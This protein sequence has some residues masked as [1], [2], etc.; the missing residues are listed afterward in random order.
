VLR[1]ASGVRPAALVGGVVESRPVMHNRW[2]GTP[3]G[4]SLFTYRLHCGIFG[5]SGFSWPANMR[6][7]RR[8]VIRVADARRS[9]NSPLSVRRIGATHATRS[10]RRMAWDLLPVCPSRAS[11]G[12]SLTQPRS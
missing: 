9:C 12:M 5:C 11:A 7:D 10:R 2:L 6:R 3:V 4:G 8:A 1:A